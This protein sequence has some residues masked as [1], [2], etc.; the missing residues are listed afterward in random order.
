[1]FKETYVVNNVD[2]DKLKATMKK[3]SYKT[4]HLEQHETHR[5]T[6]R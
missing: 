4:K 6:T 5:T 2:R 3:S 1:M